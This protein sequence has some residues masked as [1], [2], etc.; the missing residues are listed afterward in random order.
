MKVPPIVVLLATFL[1]LPS[2]GPAQ[3]DAVAVSRMR[4]APVVS[5][6]VASVGYSPHLHAL[7]IEFVRGAVYR[8]LN[9]PES[10]YRALC[11]APSKGHFIAE[12][13]RGKYEFV[14][15]NPRRTDARLPERTASR[16]N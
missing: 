14:R 10:V 15:V 6:N 13:L 16:R 3:S 4:R 12:N 9:V 8:F 1:F 5:S 2:R 11:V 7:E